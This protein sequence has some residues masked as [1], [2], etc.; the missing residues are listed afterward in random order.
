MAAILLIT[1]C[2]LLDERKMKCRNH[3]KDIPADKKW[4]L[5]LRWRMIPPWSIDKVNINKPVFP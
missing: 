2:F 5:S 3:A 1:R 4:Q